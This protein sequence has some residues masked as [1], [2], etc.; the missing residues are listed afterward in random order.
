MG[1]KSGDGASIAVLTREGSAGRRRVRVLTMRCPHCNYVSTRDVGSNGGTHYRRHLLTHTKERPYKCEFCCAGFTTNANRLRHI[2]RVHEMLYE[3]SRMRDC[4]AGDHVTF[5]LGCSS[6]RFTEVDKGADTSVNT[7]ATRDS[8]FPFAKGQLPRGYHPVGGPSLPTVP[9][10]SSTSP[11]PIECGGHTFHTAHGSGGS[12]DT[13]AGVLIGATCVC[14]D[15]E[16]ELSSSAQ[17]K[18]HLRCYCPFREDVFTQYSEDSDVD[19]HKSVTGPGVGGAF[20]DFCFSDGECRGRVGTKRSRRIIS[21][22]CAGAV[23]RLATHVRSKPELTLSP[24]V[25]ATVAASVAVGGRA[26]SR[27]TCPYDNCLATFAS[28]E[29]W[30]RHVARRHPQEA[31]PNTNHFSNGVDSY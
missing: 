31:R 25:V 8:T 15:C 2:V 10:P 4:P 16:K 5:S 13:L 23:D 12:S 26:R 17:L 21:R 20:Y 9:I 14:P 7:G 30:H 28:R 18:R 1:E 6:T 19:L 11:E 29:R 22:R 3:T 24:D 27:V